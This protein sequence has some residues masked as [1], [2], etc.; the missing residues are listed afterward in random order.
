M[1]PTL[2]CL[3]FVL[4]AVSLGLGLALLRVFSTG[5]QQESGI[6]PGEDLV[7]RYRPME[8]LLDESDFEFIAAQRIAPKMVSQL[9]N[10]RRKIFRAYLRSLRM[11]YSRLTFTLKKV[12][13]DSAV[14]RPDLAKVLFENKVLFTKTLMRVEF[15]LAVHSFGVGTVQI[16]GLVEALDSMRRQLQVLAPRQF[17]ATV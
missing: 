10:E 14:D 17:A 7:I 1:I 3:T 12:M 9:R 13:L 11:D 5:S 15:Q 8:R 16:N 6:P 4:L 2:L